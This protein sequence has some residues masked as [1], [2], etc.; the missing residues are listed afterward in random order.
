MSGVCSSCVS[1]FTC[2]ADGFK[3]LKH[4]GIELKKRKKILS[5]PKDSN[6]DH[7]RDI[8]IDKG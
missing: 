2:I 1:T 8:S 6:R 7:Y 3:Q 5:N 4:Q